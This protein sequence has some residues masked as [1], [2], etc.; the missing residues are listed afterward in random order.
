MKKLD[1]ALEIASTIN[2][3]HITQKTEDYRNFMH[4]FLEL[5]Q[6][7]HSQVNVFDIPRPVMAI[8]RE[9]IIVTSTEKGLC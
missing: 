5:V 9:C 8:K 3:Q 2:L 1:K 6:Q 7:V 4:D